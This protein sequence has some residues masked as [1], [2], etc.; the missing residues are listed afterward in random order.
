LAE[1]QHFKN[2]PLSGTTPYYTGF[3]NDKDSS[4]DSHDIHYVFVP[5]ITSPETKP[6]LLWTMGGPGAS[7]LSFWY[8]FNGPLSKDQAGL[9]INPYSFNKFANVVILEY[10]YGVGYSMNTAQ[11]DKQFTHIKNLKK[12][13]K[14]YLRV[15]KKF[16]R[17]Y[18]QYKEN[19]IWFGGDSQ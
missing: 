2:L 19:K 14:R 7:V 16:F 9:S 10:P 11:N 1:K 15:V 13:Y 6:F 17:K 5:C 3:I 4:L 18:H 8:F 12:Q